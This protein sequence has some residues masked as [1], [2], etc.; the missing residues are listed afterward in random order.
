MKVQL[1][2][3]LHELCCLQK[4]V[5]RPFVVKGEGLQVIGRRLDAVL[6]FKGQLSDCTAAA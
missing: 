6:T 5:E 1:P 3:F 2:W 4:Y